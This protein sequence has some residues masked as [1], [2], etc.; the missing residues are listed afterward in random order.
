MAMSSPA[1]LL[2]RHMMIIRY[3]E[4]RS[5]GRTANNRRSVSGMLTRLI[6]RLDFNAFTAARV[7]ETWPS[8][9]MAE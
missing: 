5:D 9:A 2:R 3:A 8:G 4:I 1:T 6:H 7:P